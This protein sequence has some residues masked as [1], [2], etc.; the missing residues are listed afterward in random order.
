VLGLSF[1][2]GVAHAAGPGHGKLVV[3]SVFLGREAQLLRG[4]ATGF[5][6]SGLQVASSAAVVGVL[7]LGLGY[8]GLDIVDRTAGVE[9]VSY[10][11]IVAVGLYMAGGAIIPERRHGLPIGDPSAAGGPRR[12]PILGATGAAILAA[13]LVPCPSALIVLLFALAN[14]AVALGIAASL[15]MAL[16]MGLTVS[17]VGLGMIA[18]RRALLGPLRSGSRALAWAGRGLTLLAGAGLIAAG[19]WLAL[20]A[21]SRLG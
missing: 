15:V 11:L 1:L 14:G 4:V 17:A 8:R 20:D 2:Y 10:G 16:G 21:W 12:A 6:V 9:L 19:G 13:G 18:G 5:L 3:A 7:A